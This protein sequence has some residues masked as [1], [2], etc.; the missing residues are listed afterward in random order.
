MSSQHKRNITS[1]ITF[2]SSW[3][4]CLFVLERT[5][6]RNEI[7]CPVMHGHLHSIFSSFWKNRNSLQCRFISLKTNTP[8][9]YVDLVHADM[10]TQQHEFPWNIFSSLRK[11]ISASLYVHLHRYK[12]KVASEWQY[13]LPLF[14]PQPQVTS[15]ERV[16]QWATKHLEEMSQHGNRPSASDHLLPGNTKQHQ[17]D[18]C[19]GWLFCF[20]AITFSP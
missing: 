7:T 13:S 2:Y 8:T 12:Q 10:L 11:E 20:I 19:I 16:Q 4:F 14:L 1:N 3:V 15:G 17:K 6:N 9:W 5:W 18:S